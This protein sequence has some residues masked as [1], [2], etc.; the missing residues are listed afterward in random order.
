M[1]NAN[2]GGTYGSR[3]EELGDFLDTLSPEERNT[4]KLLDFDESKELEHASL[5]TL[6]I[7]SWGVDWSQV[8][9]I[10]QHDTEL[11]SEAAAIIRD[12]ISS[13]IKPDSDVVVFWADL[14]IPNVRL[15]VAVA[16]KALNEIIATSFDTWLYFPREAI[17]VEHYHEGRVTITSVGNLPKP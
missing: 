7:A 5:G 9:R 12:S 1:M 15:P 10:E 13:R 14:A 6:P 4:V 17:L 8:D 3:P 2:A 16:V 11:E